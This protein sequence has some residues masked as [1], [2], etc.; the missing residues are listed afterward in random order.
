MA[1]VP[2]E[3]VTKYAQQN[4]SS[5][6]PSSQELWF[7]KLIGKPG[8]D[9]FGLSSHMLR[10]AAC[11]HLSPGLGT[12]AA[13]SVSSSSAQVCAVSGHA[14]PEHLIGEK[15]PGASKT[16]EQ[17]QGNKLHCWG[18]KPAGGPAVGCW[19]TQGV[20]GALLGDGKS[21]ARVSISCNCSSW[22][23]PLGSLANLQF[24]WEKGLLL[25]RAFTL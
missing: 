9:L 10:A 14:A 17:Q 23:S 6:P 11:L 20:G 3:T 8:M 2:R 13:G 15:R 24:C 5:P 4:Q 19:G 12:C 16:L 18:E 1:E 22:E 7:A 21:G 25:W